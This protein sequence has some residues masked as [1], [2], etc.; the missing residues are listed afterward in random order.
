MQCHPFRHCFAPLLESSR[1]ALFVFSAAIAY[2]LQQ[3]EI[4]ALASSSTMDYGVQL[5]L[6]RYFR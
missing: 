2:D 1:L 6:A 5:M 4:V 3:R